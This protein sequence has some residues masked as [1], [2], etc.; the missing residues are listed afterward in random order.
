M[1]GAYRPEI[2][3]LNEKIRSLATALAI[4]WEI[5]S[6][7]LGRAGEKVEVEGGVTERNLNKHKDNKCQLYRTQE[8]WTKL[9]SLNGLYGLIES[10]KKVSL[11]KYPSYKQ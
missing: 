5:N 1:I 7:G 10:W 2:I 3:D 8:W 4:V 9:V 6:I 11:S